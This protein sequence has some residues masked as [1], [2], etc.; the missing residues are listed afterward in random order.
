VIVAANEYMWNTTD[1]YQG[2][3]YYYGSY[4]PSGAP[5][6]ADPFPGYGIG[7]DNICR[8]PGG[9][10]FKATVDYYADG[11]TAWGDGIRFTEDKN[12]ATYFS[13]TVQE[14]PPPKLTDYGVVTSGSVLNY[15]DGGWA[16]WSVPAGNVVL[17]GG[18]ALTGGPAAVS[19]PGTPGSAWPHYTFGASEYGWVVR[20]DPDGASSPGST[21]YAVHADLPAGYEIVTSP[22]LPFS[23]SGY[24]GWSCPAGKVVLGGGFYATDRVAVSAPGT[25]GSVWP[26]YTFG[27][28]EY[29]WVIRDAQD[30]A[31]NTITV[32]AICADPVS[33]YE[34]VT[35][36]PLNYSDGGWAGWSCPAG[37]V[38][39]GGG[40][41]LTGLAAS[42][43]APGTP[44][45]A[46][47]HYT[48]GASEYGWVVR[49][50]PDGASSY[51]STVYAVCATDP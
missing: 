10:I 39:T 37:K 15:A 19:A 42:V 20:D 49:D 12:W 46:W 8:N 51:G 31:G 26:H 18:F 7:I 23:D 38:V 3:D 32:Y 6:N 43:S 33:G 2:K 11:E 14:P 22:A 30:G 25:P 44:G 29:G 40:F 13:Y 34:V 5:V 24:G 41:A 16:G 1:Q 47:P 27:A 4:D 45:S 48:F 21:V 28:D 36:A 9:L 35:S 50:A 17:G